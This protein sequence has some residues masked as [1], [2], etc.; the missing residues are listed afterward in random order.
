MFVT[1][2]YSAWSRSSFNKHPNLDHTKA[3][4]ILFRSV[5]ADEVG[6]DESGTV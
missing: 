1:F 3:I 6:D 5:D 2:D 4:K